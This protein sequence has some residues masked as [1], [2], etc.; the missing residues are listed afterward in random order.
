[1]LTLA[2]AERRRA[3]S[4]R[5]AEP[6]YGDLEADEGRAASTANAEVARLFA[7]IGDILEIKG[8]PPYRYNAYRT[9]ARSVGNASERLE[10]LFEQG[11][12][13]EL[14]GVG[15][16]L[17]GRI[18]EYLK[19]GRMQSHE[20]VRR[21]FPV[22]L[23]SLLQIP[24]L[25]PGRARAVYQELGISTLPDLEDAARSGRLRDVPGFGPKAIDTLV[26][27]LEQLK[28]RSARGLISD[29]WA[30]FAQIRA[31]LR[32]DAEDA[33]AARLAV[34][35]SVRRMQDTV[36]GLDLLAGRDTAEEAEQVLETIAT[37]PNLVQVLDRSADEV[38]VQLYGGLEVR[39]M[40]VPPET[41]GSALIWYTGS[42][43]HVARLEERALERGW[44][45]SPL[46]LEDDATGQLLERQR[47]A[48]IYERLG[49]AWVP[50]ELREDEGEIEA[51]ASGSLPKLVELGDIRG[52]LH[53]HTNWTDGTQPLEDMA[54]A[55][56][57]KGY[58]YMAL[59]DHTQN[60]AMTRGL[61][62][63]R[64]EEQR[65]LV[66]RLNK[67]MAPF[68]VL[69]GTE[70]DILMDG[71]LDFSDDLLR[72]LDYVSASVH[73][74]FRQ[75]REVMTQRMLRAISNPLVNTLNH[76]HGRIIR[77]REGYEVDMQAV[78]E[79]AAALGCA[80]EL[81][82][83]PDRLDLNGT[84]ARR[85]QQLA[86]RFTISSDAHSVQELD[87]MQFGVASARRGWLTA[88]DVLNT[89]PL[90]ELKAQLA[91]RRRA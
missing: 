12:L 14:Y 76:P 41:W 82:A 52:D 22:A 79:R 33:D 20:D 91:A 26:H 56:Q 51:A 15:S 81:N 83:T 24:G 72:S 36:G 49:M 32:D 89:L 50:P 80:L 55:A 85:A 75:G 9:A 28:Q 78:V 42:R 23:A 6:R 40:V 25:G 65:A 69:L 47:E 19:T 87:F 7:E 11:R 57:S 1:M 3:S 67:K 43:G 66:N 68:V 21:D 74:G 8:E 44:R 59:T 54:R 31:A 37:L 29:A 84:W 71:Q 35:G 64:L 10:V 17:E 90:E 61:T 88:A 34:V 4:R 5:P 2:M 30:A 73:T 39:L 53:T 13:R 70:M 38:S 45:L 46:G 62:P 48:A 86:A 77:R 18:V 16:A 58:A 27:G 63:E 60:L